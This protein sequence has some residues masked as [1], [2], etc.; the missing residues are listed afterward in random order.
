MLSEIK[1]ELSTFEEL[2]YNFARKELAPKR[3]VYDRYPFGPFYYDVITKAYEIG[4]FSIALPE[5]CGGTGYGLSALSVILERISEVDASLAGVILTNAIA[6]EL[7]L[8]SGNKKL[9]TEIADQAKDATSFLIAYPAFLNPAETRLKLK[10][11]KN[12]EHFSLN[13]SMDFLVLGGIAKYA[14]V[15]ASIEGKDG[16]AFFFIDLSDKNITKSNTV[17]SLGLHA[18]PAVDITMT[19]TRAVLLGDDAGEEY[20]EQVSKRMCTGVSAI[21]CG[22]MKGCFE[23]ALSYSQQRFQ[24]GKE[25]IKWSGLRML[26]SD[27]AIQTKIAD[28]VLTSSVLGIEQGLQQSGLYSKAGALHVSELACELTT[29]G[30]QVLGGY[31]YMKD[32][33]QEK[34]FRDAKQVQ[35]FFGLVPL[36]KLNMVGAVLKM[37]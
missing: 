37:S 7:M 27:M 18:C 1:K 9:L 25:I 28:M 30:I 10:A 15:P 14:V 16:Y 34:R 32:Y 12:D 17:F 2:A 19:D 5:D 33:G 8:V 21:Q 35:T 13:G 22:I 3:N 6:Q 23:E 24:G 36:R 29:N 26:L 11:A 4:F 20:F 31:G